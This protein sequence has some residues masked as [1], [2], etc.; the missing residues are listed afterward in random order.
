M[1]EEIY[2]VWE[3][4]NGKAYPAKWYGKKFSSITGKELEATQK[5]LLTEQERNLS[6]AELADKYPYKEP[7]NED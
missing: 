1:S 5:Y 3:L 2:F 7:P 6:F 4:S